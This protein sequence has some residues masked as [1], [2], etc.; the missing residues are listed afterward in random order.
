MGIQRLQ[1]KCTPRIENKLISWKGTWAITNFFYTYTISFLHRQPSTHQGQILALA[2]CGRVWVSFFS[3]FGGE[4]VSVSEDCVFSPFE[5]FWFATCVLSG[6]YRG[7]VECISFGFGWVAIGNNR[8]PT[9]LLVGFFFHFITG[10]TTINRQTMCVYML[11]SA[12]RLW[13]W[14]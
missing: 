7:V 9:C 12:P 6:I 4:Q 14:I 2:L 5:C 8:S 1:L 11:N 10:A 13:L 3:G